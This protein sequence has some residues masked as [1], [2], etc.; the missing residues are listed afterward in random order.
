MMKKSL[1]A[2]A[3]LA[4]SSAFAQTPPSVTVYGIADFGV[5]VD[6]KTTTTGAKTDTRS[7]I[8][9]AMLIGMNRNCTCVRQPAMA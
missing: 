3:V 1:L 7:L 2:L 4:S 9:I 5:N 8:T 6:S